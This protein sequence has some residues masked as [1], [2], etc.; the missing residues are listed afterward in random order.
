MYHEEGETHWV[1]VPFGREKLHSFCSTC[2]KGSMGDDMVTM[3]SQFVFHEVNH[4]MV[5]IPYDYE[6]QI[7]T[8][9]MI[10]ASLN[11][12]VRGEIPGDLDFIFPIEGNIITTRI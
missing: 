2:S 7:T 12:S 4:M 6:F 10:L 8:Y 5:W 1:D 3:F 11:C 9:E